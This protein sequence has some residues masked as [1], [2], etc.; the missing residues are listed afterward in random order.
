[1]DGDLKVTGRFDFYGIVIVK[2][3][4]ETAGGG[5]TGSH[6]RGAV[7]AANA[8]FDDSKVIGNAVVNY[9]SCTIQRALNS[10]GTGAMLRSRGWLYSY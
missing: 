9:S 4:L 8:F 1:V 7:M 5:N 10:A 3:T 2:G 6:F